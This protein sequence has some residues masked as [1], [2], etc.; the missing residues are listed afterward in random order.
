M[1]R[2]QRTGGLGGGGGSLGEASCTMLKNVIMA[3]LLV[4]FECFMDGRTAGMENRPLTSPLSARTMC[5][6][7]GWCT[8]LSSEVP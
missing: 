6:T 1:Q 7:A 5:C 8:G 2:L 3:L 4:L